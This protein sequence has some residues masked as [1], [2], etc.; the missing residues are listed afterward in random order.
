MCSGDEVLRPARDC[1]G[2]RSDCVGSL[3]DTGDGVLGPVLAGGGGGT[4]SADGSMSV[5]STPLTGSESGGGAGTDTVTSWSVT[6][7]GDSPASGSV[8]VS[9][10]VPASDGDTSTRSESG[11]GAGTDTVSSCSVI[12]GGGG[13]THAKYGASDAL[14]TS[15]NV[16]HVV[17]STQTPSGSCACPSGRRS[18]TA[19]PGGAL[20][21]AARRS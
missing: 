1:D 5:L 10:S 18:P 7:G 16:E 4:M 6:G 17:E 3:L 14:T 12:D 9:E 13:M 11:G 15:S 8:R 20:T 19:L 21:P 2:V